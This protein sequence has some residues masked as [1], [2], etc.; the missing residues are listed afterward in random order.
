M[1]FPIWGSLIVVGR[2]TLLYGHLLMHLKGN[3]VTWKAAVSQATDIIVK[4]DCCMQAGDPQT[5]PSGDLHDAGTIGLPTL[6]LSH[7]SL[8][9]TRLPAPAVRPALTSAVPFPE[10]RDWVIQSKEIWSLDLIS[11]TLLLFLVF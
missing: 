5:D 8:R 11:L 2:D 1:L 3:G 4:M 10:V 9:E 7:Y 6:S